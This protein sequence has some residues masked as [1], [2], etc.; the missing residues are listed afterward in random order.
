MLDHPACEIFDRYTSDPAILNNLYSLVDLLYAEKIFK[1][2]KWPEDGKE[3]LQDIGNGICVNHQILKAFAVVLQKSLATMI[4]GG[5]ILKEY[6]KLKN[7][8]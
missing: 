8:L 1:K 3:L 4:I 5:N 2:V 6:S 7:K